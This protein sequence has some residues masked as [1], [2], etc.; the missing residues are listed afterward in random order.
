M[1]W[2]PKPMAWCRAGVF[3]YIDDPEIAAIQAF[4]PAQAKE[5]L[6]GTPYEGGQNWPEITMHM[7]GRRKSLQLRPDGERHRG[8]APGKP[9]HERQHS[10]LA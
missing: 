8:P 6:V 3:G 2:P 5:Q 9:G 1:D 10:G 7:R 4:D